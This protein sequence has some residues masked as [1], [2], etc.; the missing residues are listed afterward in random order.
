MLSDSLSV[1]IARQVA[2]TARPSDVTEHE[3]HH[4]QS[5]YRAALYAPLWTDGTDLSSRTKSLALAL[6]HADEDG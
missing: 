6:A 3:W 4:V 5:L 1:I 2:D